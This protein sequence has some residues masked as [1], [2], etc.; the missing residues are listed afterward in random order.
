MLCDAC[1]NA[2]QRFGER[3]RADPI[4]FGA[5]AERGANGVHVRID[6][7]GDHGASFQID[8]ARLLPGHLAQIGGRADGDDPA[9]AH[10]DR[11]RRGKFRVDG[12]DLAVEQN[13]GGVLR[14][15]QAR[16]QQ[17]RK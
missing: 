6:Q 2:I 10:G 8:H 5:E 12:E 11:L 3:S 15:R 16:R 17:G 14:Q 13:R 1:A 7:A 4:H 9:V